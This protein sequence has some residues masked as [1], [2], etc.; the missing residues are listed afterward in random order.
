MNKN[1]L[2]KKEEKAINEQTSFTSWFSMGT[3]ETTYILTFVGIVITLVTIVLALKLSLMILLAVA[4]IVLIFALM[5]TFLNLRKK[6]MLTKFCYE[7]NELQNKTYNSYKEMEIEILNVAKQ[8]VE[9]HEEWWCECEEVAEDKVEEIL[10]DNIH[11]YNEIDIDE[12]IKKDF[13]SERKA[14]IFYYSRNK[15]DDNY[16]LFDLTQ[17]LKCAMF[18]NECDKRNIFICS[19]KPYEEIDEV[20]DMAA[21]VE[22]ILEL[23]EKFDPNMVIL[24]KETLD[25]I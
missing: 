12:N 19:D 7:I 11:L 21:Y 13:I 20:D 24:N 18:G 25:I 14:R 3:V 1:T 6:A 17:S 23:K 8:F 22:K 10:M 16:K 9:K 4:T 2:T 5:V 15:E